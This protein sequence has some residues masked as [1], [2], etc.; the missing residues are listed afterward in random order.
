MSYPC[1]PHDRQFQRYLPTLGDRC[2]ENVRAVLGAE[3]SSPAPELAKRSDPTEVETRGQQIMGCRCQASELRIGGQGPR[4]AAGKVT[5][6]HPLLRRLRP[7]KIFVATESQPRPRL[8]PFALGVRALANARG[9][10]HRGWTRP[11]AGTGSRPHFCRGREQPPGYANFKTPGTLATRTPTAQWGSSENNV[12]STR[13]PD[14]P[15]KTKRPR[16]DYAGRGRLAGRRRCLGKA[17]ALADASPMGTLEGI[18]AIPPACRCILLQTRCNPARTRGPDTTTPPGP[19]PEAEVALWTPWVES[20]GAKLPP[21][22]VNDISE[23]AM[24]SHPSL[25]KA[26]LCISCETWLL[27]IACENGGCAKEVGPMRSP[28]PQDQ[29]DGKGL[30]C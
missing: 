23:A 2:N 18:L 27:C 15:K 14:L 17:V 20:S 13:G 28:S 9:S 6:N 26:D 5:F 21:A 4:S 3:L 1:K 10:S 8:F 25:P 11:S 19:K 29:G 12:R 16:P 30:A 22:P 24:A 7:A